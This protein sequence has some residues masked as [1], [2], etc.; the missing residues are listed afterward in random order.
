[1][2]MARLTIIC[3][4]ISI[5]TFAAVNKEKAKENTSNVTAKPKLE[6]AKT[7]NGWEVGVGSYQMDNSFESGDN[8]ELS[9]RV[10][11][12]SKNFKINNRLHTKT[13]LR[14]MNASG[15]NNEKTYD[16]ETKFSHYDVSQNISFVIHQND[17]TFK[18]FVSVGFGSGD[19]IQ[20][21]D[22]FSDEDQEVLGFESLETTAYYTVSTS[23]IGLQAT[24]SNGITPFVALENTAIAF[25]DTKTAHKKSGSKRGVKIKSSMG[26]IESSVLT[27]GLIYAF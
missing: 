19:F 7:R 21:M 22:G 12:G 1:M 6:D 10:I 17:V 25:H 27:A 13:S 3:A 24:F 14:I 11:V 18:P 9:G 23:A 5:N 4:L 16:S 8:E 2:K 26:D 20:Q 15:S